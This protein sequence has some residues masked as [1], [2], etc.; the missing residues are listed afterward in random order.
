[1][2]YKGDYAPSYLLDP[3]E[4]T[5]HPL[6]ECKPLLDKFR[7]ASFAHP[8]HS[9]E[10]PDTE[11]SKFLLPTTYC[12]EANSDNISDPPCFT[13][14]D[15]G[16]PTTSRLR[17][18]RKSYGGARDSEFRFSC[19]VGDTNCVQHTDDWDR[20][21]VKRAITTVAVGLG[22]DLSRRVIFYLAHVL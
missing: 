4:Y 22:P 9:A 19:S 20:A 21:A 8:E 16:K 2:R 11:R 7:Y 10:S 1:M 17:S 12:V 14:I 18:Q 13:R 3:E 15:A 6:E 5:W